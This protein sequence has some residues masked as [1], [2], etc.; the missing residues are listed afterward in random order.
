MGAHHRCGS[1]ILEMINLESLLFESDILLTCGAC[2]TSWAVAEER[3]FTR[4]SA[5]LNISQP[6]PVRSGIKA[7]ESEMGVQLLVRDRRGVA[8]TGRGSSFS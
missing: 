8:P 6:L 5:R 2:G 4:A 3:S 1:S 7:L